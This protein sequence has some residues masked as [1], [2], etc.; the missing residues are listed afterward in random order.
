MKSS[1]RFSQVDFD[2]GNCPTFHNQIKGIHNI[3]LAVNNRLPGECLTLQPC[4]FCITV[5]VR[6]E[7][8]T[9]VLM[10]PDV[11]WF[12]CGNA[13]APHISR[14]PVLMLRPR[15]WNMV[16]H[17]MMVTCYC[18]VNSHCLRLLWMHGCHLNH[19]TDCVCH[20]DGK[21][22]GF[23]SL[24][25]D[26]YWNQNHQVEGKEAPGP[27][28]DFGLLMYHCGRTLL[29]HQSGPFFYLSKVKSK[30]QTAFLWLFQV[31]ISHAALQVEGN[32][33]I[34]FHHK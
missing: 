8:R 26:I 33:F 4:S 21:A 13:G 3:I 24:H 7:D 15:A 28:F 31:S 17:N 30:P 10:S 16:E 14:A 18:Y 25:V 11:F 1:F 29:E 19:L 2:D 20:G 23:G 32:I 27:L 34:C 22:E 9:L 12:S 6:V 5:F